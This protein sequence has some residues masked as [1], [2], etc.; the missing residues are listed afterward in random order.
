MGTPESMHSPLDAFCALIVEDMRIMPTHISMYVALWHAWQQNGSEG[1]VLL[2]KAALMRAAKISARQ[3][4]HDALRGLHAFGYIRYEP[5]ADPRIK[6]RVWLTASGTA[7][8]PVIK[9]K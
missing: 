8:H 1:P 7:A 2:D 5:S 9:M 3:T 4:Y 6:S